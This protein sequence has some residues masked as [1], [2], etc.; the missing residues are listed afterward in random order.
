M[1]RFAIV[2]A[3]LLLAQVTEPLR[4]Q[5]P[6]VL[7]DR[8]G[9]PLPAH[10][11]AR[12]G[13]THWRHAGTVTAAAFLPD[14]KT[15]LTAGE[16]G[17]IR[18]WELATGRELRTFDPVPKNKVPNE[19]DMDFG[20]PLAVAISADGKTLASTGHDGRV[21]IWDVATGKLR[22]SFLPSAG[23]QSAEFIPP[24]A[25]AL[26]PDGKTLAVTDQACQLHLC[27]TEKG[28]MRSL[29]AMAQAG[30]GN[31]FGGVALNVAFSPD[32]KYLVSAGYHAE[33]NNNNNNNPSS[34]VR[35]W[36]V[37]SGKKL[38]TH[39]QKDQNVGFVTVFSPDNK[40]LAVTGS[41]GGILLYD[42][43]NKKL[44]K[45]LR[46]DGEFS[47]GM[48]FS[49][50]GKN[51]LVKSMA[52][53]SVRVIEL[54][55]GKEAKR[56][57][58]NTR[59]N[60]VEAVGGN[61]IS[62]NGL[63]LS[64][65]GKQ[66]AIVG[67]S[68]SL[69][70]LDVTSG[71]EL[72]IPVGHV[73]PVGWLRF[74]PDKKT[75]LSM[76]DD[77]VFCTWDGST[78]AAQKRILH[79][80]RDVG[81][82]PAVSPNGKLL[83]AWGANGIELHDA[84]TKKRIRT[85]ATPQGGAMETLAFSPNNQVLAGL[86]M[87]EQAELY[88][89]D[90]ASGKE[91]R[92]QV[93]A[94]CNMGMIEQGLVFSP[95]SRLIVLPGSTDTSLVLYEVATGKELRRIECPE[96]MGLPRNIAFAPDG[97]SLLLDHGPNT[98]RLHEVATGQERRSF[99]EKNVDPNADVPLN[100]NP[101]EPMIDVMATAF[102]PDGQLVAQGCPDSSIGL[103]DVTAGRKLGEFKG[104]QGEVLTLAFSSDGKRLISGSTDT[105]ILVWDVTRLSPPGPPTGREL[106]PQEL[107]S[108]WADLLDQN[109]TKSFL[110]LELLAG[111]PKQS[112]PFL[113]EQL[114]KQQPPLNIKQVE[115]WLQDLDNPRYAV[116]QRATIE[117]AKLNDDV[118]ANLQKALDRDP[119]PE[120][121]QRL[122][123]LLEHTGE[124][125]LRGERLRTMR[126]IE[127]LDRLDSVEAREVLKYLAAGPAP[128]PLT[129]EARWS[130]QRREQ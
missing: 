69:R 99:G 49:P 112:L 10:A 37:A 3:C 73:G 116:R 110:A 35:L 44:W 94:D 117:L 118:Q 63:A 8:F 83:A 120:A 85:I 20:L 108:C 127:L 46:P 114:L 30:G 33:N 41:N 89:F 64:A 98:M 15:L 100:L 32:G 24:G 54:E 48:V 43:E 25:L 5:P 22:K 123:E 12:L 40:R 109:S 28:T 77:G 92:H 81:G 9:D 103:W 86:S 4:A 95:D 115:Q 18:V 50:D 2:S 126:A 113:R 36:D 52:N 105:T 39:E 29:S 65:D 79:R 60:P 42:V 19:E 75:I 76:S 38:F 6:A 121:R 101:R 59:G 16:D 91:L 21:H 13:T 68:N 47:G 34:Q 96:N 31:R 87:N 58:K 1:S 128:S 7:K 23:K 74:G 66:L 80:I 26:S 51:L 104:H 90:V 70:L 57:D 67:E 78:G 84:L 55:T 14:G 125:Y 11:L 93:I 88:L 111:S 53:S 119:G 130:L 129:R 102:S 71:K 82:M 62:F 72:I 97:R 107:Q 45:K 124:R 122:R 56:L 106:S 17:R 61:Q 27:S